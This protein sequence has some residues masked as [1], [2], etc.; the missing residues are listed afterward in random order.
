MSG[1]SRRF[2]RVLVIDDEPADVELLRHGL[3]SVASADV[4]HVAKPGPSGTFV[5]GLDA[6]A[7]DLIVL[8]WRLCGDQAEEIAEAYF[9]RAELAAKVRLV[10]MSG[11]VHASATAAL[12]AKGAVVIEKSLSLEGYR[13]IGGQLL[14]LCEAS[15]ARPILSRLKQETAAIHAQVEQRVDLLNRV[16]TVRAYRALL[17]T[18]YGLYCPL[19]AEVYAV[20]AGIGLWLADWEE[21]RRLELIRTDL[22]ALGAT[23]TAG[24]ALAP[25]PRFTS[26]A[27]R[28]GC[29]YV[30]EGSTLGGQVIAR[31]IQEHLGF[32]A[33]NG[34]AFF[35]SHG[36]KIGEM[37]KRF[38]AAIESFAAAH[39]EAGDEVVQSAGATFH[40]FQDW[41]GERL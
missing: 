6:S 37:W 25:V 23:D 20:E 7:F 33:D 13:A 18:F 36:P 26:I 3:A 28:F 38:G 41:I 2:I 5:S 31:H 29:L 16:R 24:L 34:C 12:R 19:E 22:K 8:D 17:E 27:A 14:A 40:V 32:T 39:P 9:L 15:D 1:A 4:V 10:V 11:Y 35:T 30:L 21:R